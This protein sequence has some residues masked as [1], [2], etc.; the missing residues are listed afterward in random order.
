MYF[1]FCRNGEYKEK[2]EKTTD[3]TTLADNRCKL[4]FSFYIDVFNFRCS[5]MEDGDKQGVW[6][7]GVVLGVALFRF[8]SSLA[9][10]NEAEGSFFKISNLTKSLENVFSLLYISRSFIEMH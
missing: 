8:F 4:I 3:F 7:V 1:I 2:V 10:L 6:W 9:L 5:V